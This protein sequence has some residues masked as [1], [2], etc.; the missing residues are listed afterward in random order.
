MSLGA[1]AIVF[2][3]MAAAWPQVA[4]LTFVIL[5]GWYALADGVMSLV[6]AFSPF[7]RPARG[8]LVFNGVIGIIAGVYA[9]FQPGVGAIA[10]TWVLSI[11]MILRGLAELAS[12]FG[13][14]QLA[15]RWLVVL[16]GLAWLAAGIIFA[17]RPGE[18]VL[19][20]SMWLGILAV[21]WGAMLLVAG[22]AARRKANL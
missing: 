14:L 15:P 22:F 16:G 21:F 4:V 2:G 5:W 10:L 18:S 9:V 20:L 8:W 13:Q 19:A 7:G 6:A 1:L 11:W 12:A 17:A 3:I